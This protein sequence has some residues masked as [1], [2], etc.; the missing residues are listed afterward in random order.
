MPRTAL[1]ASP[2]KAQAPLFR[3]M[4][5][6]LL[7]AWH[8]RN[9][10]KGWYVLTDISGTLIFGHRSDS[11]RRS[12]GMRGHPFKVGLPPHAGQVRRCGQDSRSRPRLPRRLRQRKGRLALRRH[13]RDVL[14]QALRVV[15]RAASLAP[16][17]LPSWASPRKMY[18]AL[19]G[20]G[21]FTIM[22]FQKVIVS[23]ATI[24]NLDDAILLG[25]LLSFTKVGLR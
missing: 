19:V 25:L 12:A 9:V 24:S 3:V 14:L 5:H 21:R 1:V 20:K 22:V 10:I 4:Y 17:L 11:Y 23:K 6:K 18:W 7:Q 16:P 13:S 8:T 15:Q 2:P